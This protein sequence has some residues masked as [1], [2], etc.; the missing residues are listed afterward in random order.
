[1]AIKS[2]R[3]G[4]KV[5]D[6]EGGAVSSDGNVIGTYI[7]GIFD[8]DGF[9]HAFLNCIRR[10]KGLPLLS[11]DENKSDRRSAIDWDREYNKL[12]DLVRSNIDMS[13]VYGIINKKT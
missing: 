8:N 5:P 3:S 12:A 4:E 1:M 13:K 9:R 2:H 11:I 6:D 10:K 7:H